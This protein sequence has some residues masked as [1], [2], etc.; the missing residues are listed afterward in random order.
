MSKISFPWIISVYISQEISPA[1]VRLRQITVVFEN[2]YIYINR[3]MM[4]S[5]VSFT[6]EVNRAVNWELLQ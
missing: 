6:Y 3:S 5:M 1:D 4:D 2:I